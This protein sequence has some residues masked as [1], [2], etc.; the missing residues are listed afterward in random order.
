[1]RTLLSRWL[2]N[3]RT[4]PR[5]TYLIVGI[6]FAATAF[7]L[8]IAASQGVSLLGRERYDDALFLRIAQ[9][10]RVG[11]WLGAYNN[12]PL[13]K[14]PIFPLWIAVVS[15]LSVPLP[16]ANQLLYAAAC[17]LIVLVTRPF[18]HNKWS[19]TGLYLV[20]LFNPVTTA[21]GPATRVLRENVYPAL[22]LL[23]VACA[24]GLWTRVGEAPRRW[25]PW[26]VALGA[27]GGTFW[28][29]RE[30]GLWLIPLLLLPVFGLAISAS[31][32]P[33]R[34]RRAA[35]T[36]L[37][38]IV[39]LMLGVVVVTAFA[40]T[41]RLVYGVGVVTDTNAGSFP[42]A[43]GALL[44]ITPERW[45]ADAPVPTEVRKRAY[46]A[47]P[48]F[49]SLAPKLEQWLENAPPQQKNADGEIKGGWFQW[50]LR[51]VAAQ[52]GV[53]ADAK[54]ADSFFGKVASEINAA[55][56][57]GRI[58]C[59]PARTGLMPPL[60]SQ[61][62]G[63]VA[64]TAWGAVIYLATFED[65]ASRP[66]KSSL[67]PREKPQIT[68]SSV[69]RLVHAPLAGVDAPPRFHRPGQWMLAALLTL[70][71]WLTPLAAIAAM[72]ATLLSLGRALK[73]RTD[74]DA[75]QMAGLLVT[76]AAL[77]FARIALVSLVDVT[78][79]SAVTAIYLAPAYGIMILWAYLA[80]TFL[81]TALRTSMRRNVGA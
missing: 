67:S 58:E 53:Y 23:V 75:V 61:Y 17:G 72:F 13:A 3:L 77:V 57:D 62:L 63:P 7:K 2:V 41:N 31:S 11:R 20:L 65:V 15:R 76:L 28:L 79:F 49:E 9:S 22:T 51:D 52:Y 47:S 81:V 68:R 46:A 12:L 24:I 4:A 19:S 59:G 56:E 74:P 48:T 55:C 33:K 54:M 70:Y 10:I 36:V 44:R 27:A 25:L 42:A 34:L 40:Q 29:T 18:L 71:R 66:T 64:S 73:N 43:Y 21:D 6:V 80:V 1:M 16:I 38:W 14:G 69:A 45:Q 78:S 30:E 26:T 37:P 39:A 60:K 35:R 50:Y 5:S 32:Q 8:L